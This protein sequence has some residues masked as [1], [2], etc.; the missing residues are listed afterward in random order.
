MDIKVYELT[1]GQFGAGLPEDDETIGVG[2]VN[3]TDNTEGYYLG[4]IDTRSR[5]PHVFEYYPEKLLPTNS[6][7]SPEECYLN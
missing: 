4:Q 7:L 2:Y 6:T 1:A 3:G 5:N